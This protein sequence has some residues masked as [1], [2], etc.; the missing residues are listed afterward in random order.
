MG[1][2]INNG[3]GFVCNTVHKECGL[4]QNDSVQWVLRLSFSLVPCVFVTMGIICLFFYPKS[5]RSELG[6]EQLLEAITKLRRGE[7]VEDPWRPGSWI[8]PAS[9]PTPNQGALSYFTPNELKAALNGQA[10]DAKLA[11]IRELIR[12]PLIMAIFFSIWMPVGVVI[13]VSGMED[14]FDDLGASVSPLG[15]MLFGIGLLGFWFHGLRSYAAW[16]LRS[17]GVTVDEVRSKYN[18]LC[19]FIGGLRIK[20]DLDSSIEARAGIEMTSPNT[21]EANPA[22]TAMGNPVP[23]PT[24]GL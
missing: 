4:M 21:E 16:H 12:W 7:T 2:Y 13:I 10:A 18:A 6:H 15:L 17:A 1:E 8:S 11:S 23:S 19:P 3:I 5:A 22:A 14:L 20:M 9:P 24:L